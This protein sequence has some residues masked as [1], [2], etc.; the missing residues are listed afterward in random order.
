MCLKVVSLFF[1]ISLR[2]AG[3]ELLLL[4]C[5]NSSFCSFQL[6]MEMSQFDEKLLLFNN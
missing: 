4:I 6:L 5:F 2:K 3:F 1:T